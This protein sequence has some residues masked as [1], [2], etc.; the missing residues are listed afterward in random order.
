[1]RYHLIFLFLSSSV[2]ATESNPLM[3]VQDIQQHALSNINLTN[4]TGNAISTYGIAITSYDDNNYYCSGGI[5][6]G[7]N[8]LGYVASV[9]QFKANQTLAIGQ[10]YLYNLIYNGIYTIVN[11]AGSSPCQ[12]PGCSWPL[13]NPT[14]WYIKIN[15]LSLDSNYTSSTY[16][17]IPYP[18]SNAIPMGEATSSIAYHYNYQLVDDAQQVC[19]GPISC[20]DQSLNCWVSTPQNQIFKAY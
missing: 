18:P 8:A 9:V 4:G 2:W 10:N 17:H 13:D 12:L 1:M 7:D 19:I 6:S 5:I 15:I 3:S 16:T 11:S 14:N 20:D